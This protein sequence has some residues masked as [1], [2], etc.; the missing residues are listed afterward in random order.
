MEK[1]LNKEQLQAIKH[2]GSP[3]LIIAGAGTGK[4][5]V[6]TE[7]IKH[8]IEKGLAKPSEILALTFT[9]KAATEMEERVDVM[10]PYGY[11]QMWIMTFHGFCDRVLRE[12]GIHIGLSPDYNLMT[13]A[14][15]VDLIRRHLFDF[16]LD[17]FRPLGN[18]NKFIQGLLQ[19]FSRLQDEGVTPLDYMKWIKAHKDKDELEQK[20]WAELAGAYQKYAEIKIAENRLDFGDLI[21]YALRLFRDRP[22]VL[23]TYRDKFKYILVDEYQDTNFAQN[24]LVR[25]L[26]GKGENLTVVSDDDQSIYGW[27]GS[28]VVNILNFRKHF[29]Q[30][31]VITL[32]TN[33]RSG[34][35]ILDKAYDLIQHNNPNRLEVVEKIDKKLKSTDKGGAVEY[36]HFKNGDDE[37]EWVAEKISSEVTQGG[38]SDG[39]FRYSD[40][41]ILVRANDHAEPFIKALDRLGIPNQFLGPQKLFKQPEIIDLIAYLKVIADPSDSLALSRVLAMD[42]W[43][44]P[45]TDLSLLNSK[46]RKTNSSLFLVIVDHEPTKKVLTLINE[47]LEMSRTKTAGEVLYDFLE[48]SGALRTLLEAVNPE[49]V[50]KVQNIAKFFAK[51][52]SFENNHEDA[53]VVVVSDWIDLL[54]GLGDSPKAT[55][56]DWN[57]NNAV[58]ILTIHSAKGLEFP[59]VFL[60]NLV[61]QRFPSMNRSEQIPIPDDLIKESLPSGDYHLEEE[62]RLFYVGMTR[63]K[64]KLYLTSADFYGDG[65][66]QKKI[67][68]FVYEALGEISNNIQQT[69]PNMVR[70]KKQPMSKPLSSKPLNLL[71]SYLSVSQI[72]TFQTCPLH[73]KLNYILNIPHPPSAAISFGISIHEALKDFYTGILA[74]GKPTEKT[75]FD[76]LANHWVNA[77]Y[78]SKAHEQKMLE[79]GKLYLSGFLTEGFNPKIKN[80]LTEHKFSLPLS[81][82]YK[83]QYGQEPLKIGG[84][85]DRVDVLPDGTLEITDYKTGAKVPTQKEVDQ[86]LQLSFYALAATHVAELPL[87]VAPEKIKLSLY[88]LDT[89]EKITTTRSVKDL[90]KV[91]DEIFKIRQEITVSDFACSNSFFC[92]NCEY[93]LLCNG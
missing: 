24:E 80:V 60:V 33:Y 21:S 72:E 56:G 13:E 16:E 51:I 43:A 45:M 11:T 74:G 62:R 47:H 91:A 53:S 35:N 64:E 25:L 63:A 71:V 44:L 30:T 92:K 3:L 48:K 61:S 85:I 46:A 59:V 22:N 41:A 87:G 84:K 23:K 8:L 12:S 68:P 83:D 49:D 70:N 38:S 10:L 9:E 90:E 26:A 18:P 81:K 19:H 5:T 7:R 52:K 36:K 6:V 66:R 1:K 15:S 55:E 14:E 78:A 32:T 88:Y 34:Q 31:K 73:Y 17:Y 89:Q 86:D 77:G 50:V 42:V 76:S 82:I 79:R 58:N 67:S 4:T 37:A 27:R 93:K 57:N 69:T 28:S 65:V 39:D 40:I 20:K 75:I 54:T 29:P 2:T